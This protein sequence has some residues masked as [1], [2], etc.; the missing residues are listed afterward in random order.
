MPQCQILDIDVEHGDASP[1]SRRQLGPGRLE[2]SFAV[3]KLLG[4]IYDSD[5]ADG[6]GDHFGKEVTP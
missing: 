2:L 6:G 5:H 1:G 4:A 3:H